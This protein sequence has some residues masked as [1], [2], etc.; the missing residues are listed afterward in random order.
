MIKSSNFDDFEQVIIKIS[1][2]AAF[3]Q[4]RQY[5]NKSP[6]RETGCPSNPYFLLTSCSGIQFF[7]SLNIVS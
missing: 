6:L 4:A 5:Y 7:N 3:E 2:F 1:N